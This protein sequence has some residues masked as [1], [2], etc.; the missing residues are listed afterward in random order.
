MKAN[1]IHNNLKLASCGNG[2]DFLFRES[3]R[4]HPQGA[5]GITIDTKVDNLLKEM[6][7]FSNSSM[8]DD[9]TE[10]IMLHE[11][12]TRIHSSA[13]DLYESITS[14]ENEGLVLYAEA[15]L[16][17]LLKNLWTKSWN[18][19]IKLKD[20]VVKFF[21]W[22]FKGGNKKE[23]DLSFSSNGFKLSHEALLKTF[24]AEKA[25]SIMD[26]LSSGREKKMPMMAN[27]NDAKALMKKGITGDG[28]PE[29]IAR[30]FA[31]L[32]S[33]VTVA[34]GSLTKDTMH[35]NAIVKVFGDGVSNSFMELVGM[36]KTKESK[37]GLFK[38]KTSDRTL[39]DVVRMSMKF[40]EENK[41]VAEEFPVLDFNTIA[42]NNKAGLKLPT[43]KTLAFYNTNIT[44][45]GMSK[46]LVKPIEGMT[47]AIKALVGGISMDGFDYDVMAGVLKTIDEY[48]TANTKFLTDLK[49]TLGMPKASTPTEDVMK[50]IDA[51]L[52]FCFEV[53]MGKSEGM[54][55]WPIDKVLNGLN[56]AGVVV[57]GNLTIAQLSALIKYN[58]ID[59]LLKEADKEIGAVD[60]EKVDDKKSSEIVN[61]KFGEAADNSALAALANGDKSSS[62]SSPNNKEEA[63]ANPIGGDDNTSKFSSTADNMKK[64]TVNND[65]NK[66]KQ[67]EADAK[68]TKQYAKSQDKLATYLN[69]V[70]K[71][72]DKLGTVQTI[73]D[74]TKIDDIKKSIEYIA[75]LMGDFPYDNNFKSVKKFIQIEGASTKMMMNMFNTIKESLVIIKDINESTRA[76]PGDMALRI[77]GITKI[78]IIASDSYSLV[79][80]VKSSVAKKKEGG[81][82][83]KKKP[84][85]EEDKNLKD[86][87]KKGE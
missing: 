37:E 80:N 46:D 4:R 3:F 48:N 1:T 8:Y 20:I 33:K 70:R 39:R 85:P 50:A 11:S 9:E 5:M 61:V 57:P 73:A 77:W 82:I 36:A 81:G 6:R 25:K 23:N 69:K 79:Q 71:E 66:Q 2:A 86:L 78:F 55:D 27:E 53:F 12:A 84:K 21:T 72:R 54:M 83:F 16:M 22:M 52:G 47:N 15:K 74:I 13:I 14:L 67:A 31:I 7:I 17:S 60:G 56:E 24:P 42:S 76:I 38:K 59:L 45:E 58:N 35:Q 62:S 49:N 18:I 63:K 40:S 32:C 30:L 43:E 44:K 87:A 19:V 10:L 29:D 65:S 41:N 34:S 28:S 68:N 64:S 75:K 26:T 51:T